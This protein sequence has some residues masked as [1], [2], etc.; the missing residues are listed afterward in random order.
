[1][2]THSLTEYK[3]YLQNLRG[4]LEQN[5]SEATVEENKVIFKKAKE[6]M[7]APGVR[8]IEEDD[9]P[10]FSG[11]SSCIPDYESKEQSEAAKK[12]RDFMDSQLQQNGLSVKGI[13]MLD[14]DREALPITQVN[15][16]EAYNRLLAEQPLTTEAALQ[17]IGGIQTFEEA[18]DSFF[19]G[20]LTAEPEE[21]SLDKFFTVSSYDD[22]LKN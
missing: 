2:R 16:N 1:L 17:F 14:R 20:F 12:V 4:V 11:G 19:Q 15:F 13:D 22:S 8:I 7:K 18:Q 10:F 9:F 3:I 21:N 6:S 5:Q